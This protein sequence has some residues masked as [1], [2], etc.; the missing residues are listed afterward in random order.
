M[1]T[2]RRALARLLV[3]TGVAALSWSG[4]VAARA[5]Y[6]QYELAKDLPERHEVQAPAPGSTLGLLEIPRLSLSS[7]VM[8][9][10]DEASLLIAAGHL[11]DTPLP[12]EPGNSAVAA[13]RDADFRPLKDIQ[14]GDVIRF[15]MAD[16]LL[17]Y[18]VRETRIVEQT[19]VSVLNPTK[20]PTLTLITCYP[21]NFIG[22]APK[23]FIVQAERVGSPR[24]T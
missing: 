18:V 6:V 7:I 19:E 5:D 4:Y 23:R 10:D 1:R 2:V 24:G 16:S 14:V 20:E 9:G 8:E 12:W 11:P 13:H 15:H 21:F 22:A 3:I 17:E